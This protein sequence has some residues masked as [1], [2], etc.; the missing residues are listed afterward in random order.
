MTLRS[1]QSLMTSDILHIICRWTVLHCSWHQINT[2]WTEKKIV[3]IN[4]FANSCIMPELPNITFYEQMK[5][6]TWN[7]FALRINFW[8]NFSA[9]AHP[10]GSPL[11]LQAL[12]GFPQRLLVES[13]HRKFLTCLQLLSFEQLLLVCSKNK[14]FRIK[15]IY[16]K[17]LLTV[18]QTYLLKTVICLTKISMTLAFVSDYSS[19]NFKEKKLVLRLKL[20]RL[21]PDVVVLKREMT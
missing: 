15:L 11:L 4:S 7:Y 21:W 12:F 2:N 6:K 20:M 10:L 14:N 17:S 9:T 19:M 18:L 1:L 8:Q 13:I 5:K 16:W 3:A